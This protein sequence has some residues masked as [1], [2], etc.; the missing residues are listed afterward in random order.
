MHEQNKK[1]SKE[2]VA[3]K[4]KILELKNTIT[5]LKNSIEGFNGRLH[6]VEETMSKLRQGSLIHP[7]RRV[8]EKTAKKG[9]DSLRKSWYISQQINICIISIPE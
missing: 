8:K 5:E 1:F 7:V 3:I 2:T 9:E 4:K 6:E